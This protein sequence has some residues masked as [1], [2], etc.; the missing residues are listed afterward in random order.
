MLSTV[1]G[2]AHVAFMLHLLAIFTVLASELRVR[3]AR[4]RSM[5]EELLSLRW[6]AMP[7]GE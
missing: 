7:M 4:V 3:V 5:L 6:S 1:D 2:R